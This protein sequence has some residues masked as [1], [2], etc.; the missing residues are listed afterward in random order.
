MTL[1]DERSEIGDLDRHLADLCARLCGNPDLLLAQSIGLVC[2]VTAA[3]HICVNL[4]DWAGQSLNGEED[5][6]VAPPLESWC[7]ALWRSGI[8]GRPGDVHPFILDEAGRLYLYRYWSYE[9][10][11]A[12]DLL[13]RIADPPAVDGAA[14]DR[15]LDR[16]FPP[17]ADGPPDRQ[18][19]AAA[20]AARQRLTIISGGPGTGKTSTIVRILALLC[21][22]GVRADRIKLA[23]PTGKAAARMQDAI[24]AHRTVF[25]EAGG[26]GM[27]LEAATLHRLLGYQP[28]SVR[29][30]HD[31]E[32]P[33]PADVVVVDEASMVDLALMAKLV[34]AMPPRARLILL[35][36][37]DQLASV[38][39]GA[40]LGDLCAGASGLGEPGESDGPGIRRC[41]VELDRSYR[42][43]AA[44]G[45]GQLSRLINKG[46]G[47][48][49]R[50]FL[51]RG[52]SADVVWHSVA[53][54]GE[55]AERLSAEVD[56]A[57][58]L[59]ADSAEAALST[60]DR[61]RML[62]AHRGGPFG[63]AL[64]N[65]R[66]ED[67]LVRRGLIRPSSGWYTGCPVLV[68]ANDYN[69]KLFNG[70]LGVALTDAGGSCRVCFRGEQGVRRFPPARLPQH[71]TAFV[72]TVHRSQGSEADEILLV[73]PPELTPVLT[74]ELLYTAVT[75]AKQ[76]VRIW[77]PTPVIEAAVTRRLTRSSGL[78]DALWGRENSR[79]SAQSA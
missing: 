57:P 47:K 37:K 18:R 52:E 12:G 58:L 54:R 6:P 41:I 77:A 40:V 70:D 8:V 75:R 69:L 73:L 61:F 43:G 3:G 51:E 19:L 33:L 39:A 60:L 13:A 66:I 23:A 53:H 30:R 5:G 56:F 78:R 38:E 28:G 49:V 9:Q 26:E 21:S 71:E 67:G 36:D 44:S 34:R 29:F 68:T 15:C 50:A 45:I 48:E 32:N 79:E 11:L 24:R 4:A 46:A 17:G 55:L 64:L 22:L 20:V 25:D 14:L 74:R 31:R 35:G 27:P 65:E 76:R 2:R 72:M 7:M 1:L 10:T 59:T 62:A 16:F 42:F 63:V